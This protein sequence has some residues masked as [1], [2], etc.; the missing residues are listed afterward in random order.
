MRELRT[1]SLLTNETANA[2]E[3]APVGG[4]G[5]RI[6][7]RLTRLEAML[8]LV[9]TTGCDQRFAR[10]EVGLNGVGR[11]HV[12]CLRQ[13]IGHRDRFVVRTSPDRK[14][15]AQYFERPL[16]PSHGLRAVGTVSV[17]R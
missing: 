12:R 15:D 9:Y 16:V 6:E 11:R 2:E 17:A 1:S 8:C 7:A 10:G 5:L 13:G 3:L 14:L 4:S